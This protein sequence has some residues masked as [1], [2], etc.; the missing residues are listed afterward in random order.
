MKNKKD[1]FMEYMETH[2]EVVAF[3]TERLLND[4]IDTGVIFET[5]Q[6]SGT[7]GIYELAIEWTNEFMAAND[8]RLWDGEF[9]DEIE[10][11]CMKKDSSSQNRYRSVFNWIKNPEAE[12]NKAKEI[13]NQAG[14]YTQGLWSYIDIQTYYDKEYPSEPALDKD[15]AID[16]LNAIPFDAEQGVTW[17]HIRVAVDD[18]MLGILKTKENEA[19]PR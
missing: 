17:E 9:F 19:S 3:I 18:Y 8:G 11:F 10:E 15:V 5:A 7:G 12:I 2:H 4:D 14:Y 1:D 13:L 6:E 16:I